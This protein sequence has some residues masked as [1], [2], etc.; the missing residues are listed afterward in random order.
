[1]KILFTHKL[2]HQI[3]K[4]KSINMM[5]KHKN[6]QN[7]YMYIKSNT[8]INEMSKILSRMETQDQEYENLLEK[9]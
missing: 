1:M 2:F 8:N 9:V 4:C 3:I 7:S 5:E 6:I